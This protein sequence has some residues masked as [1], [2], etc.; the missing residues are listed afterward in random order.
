MSIEQ[1]VN[2]TLHHQPDVEVQQQIVRAR[3]GQ[4]QAAQGTFDTQLY[5]NISQTTNRKVHINTG[6]AL[7]TLQCDVGL[8]RTFESGL[9]V[10]PLLSAAMIREFGQAKFFN[11][12]A[13][14]SFVYPLMRGRD[15]SSI[16][17]QA[18]YHLEAAELRLQH[19]RMLN[20]QQTALAYWQAQVTQQIALLWQK[21]QER[22]QTKQDPLFV[23]Y[24]ATYADFSLQ[25][26]TQW[27]QARQQL[28]VTMNLALDQITTLN[29]LSSHFPKPKSVPSV[30]ML[31]NDVPMKRADYRAFEKDRQAFSESVVLARDAMRTRMDVGVAVR[32]EGFRGLNNSNISGPNTSINLS[33]D[34]PWQNRVAKSQVAIA[35]SSE[36][37]QAVQ[38][39]A[40]L[41]RI[42]N[43]I[44]VLSKAITLYQQRIQKT[45]M[46][47]TSY[48]KALNTEKDKFR[49]M[50]IHDRYIS[51]RIR[52]I[53][54]QGD[55]AKTWIQLRFAAGDLLVDGQ[56]YTH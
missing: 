54:A 27:L 5:S 1:A 42:C 14:I 8:N 32:Y 55:Y 21:A 12:S 24:Q 52:A 48:L 44:D 3:Q 35:Q 53:Q 23:A 50:D 4:L 56:L 17:T 20:A 49:W 43:E 47:S 22:I 45:S 38:R 36:Q 40:L 10:S 28:A 51:S 41:R 46:A 13:S 6:L 39:D 31:M 26:Q 25:A 29:Q 15:I 11:N 30:T 19:Q 37:Q 18:S 2:I 9:R 34:L 33:M 7:D 16:Q